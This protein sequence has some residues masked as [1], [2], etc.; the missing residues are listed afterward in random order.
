MQ[1]KNSR[2]H[3]S[4]E[5]LKASELKEVKNKNERILLKLRLITN[6]LFKALSESLH[7]EKTSYDQQV[8]RVLSEIQ[9][10]FRYIDYLESS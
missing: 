6:D 10:H 7:L 5:Y 4:I 1:T 8:E 2:Y 3:Q 9:S